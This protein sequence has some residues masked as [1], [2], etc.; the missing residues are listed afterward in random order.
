MNKF[1]QMKIILCGFFVLASFFS[2]HAFAQKTLASSLEIYV[3]PKDG[4]DSS[5]QSRDE[6]AC[7]EWAT[8][9]SGVD[10]FAASKQ[11]AAAQEQAQQSQQHVA[12]ASKGAGGRGLIGGALAGAV[13]GEIVDD[14]SSKGAAYG[15]AAGAIMARRRAAEAQH[16]AQQQ[17]QQQVA[18]AHQLSAEQITNFKKAFSVCLEG[19][20]YLVKY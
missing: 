5:Q 20:S 13:I 17:G 11:T 19:K 4:Q 7:Y 8:T 1:L 15:A 16:Q 6:T 10:P 18:Q 9:N 12:E 3:F 14:D 2:A